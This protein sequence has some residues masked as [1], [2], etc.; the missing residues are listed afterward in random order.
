[1]AESKDHHFQSAGDVFPVQPRMALAFFAASV[2]CWLTFSLVLTRNSQLLLCRAS[3]QLLSSWLAPRNYSPCARLCMPLCW[4]FSGLQ[5]RPVS[6]HVLKSLRERI[7]LVT[8]PHPFLFTA[9]GLCSERRR[10]NWTVQKLLWPFGQWKHQKEFNNIWSF[11]FS[12]VWEGRYCHKYVL[13]KE[14]TC[15]DLQ[16]ARS[17]FMPFRVFQRI[18][19]DFFT[20]RWTG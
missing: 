10:E 19:S 12:S 9:Q 4:I 20:W 13:I 8:A 18:D 17:V 16:I 14:T 6:K 3:F 5:E 1:M 11:K 15:G 7:A 2:C